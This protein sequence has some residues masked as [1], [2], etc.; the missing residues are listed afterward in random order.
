[1]G[2]FFLAEGESALAAASLG[3]GGFS[4]HPRRFG[5]LGQQ[6]HDSFI[7]ALYLPLDELV[8][9]PALPKDKQ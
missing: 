4:G 1:L 6:E 5:Q 9:L 3:G 2:F 8:A 7:Q